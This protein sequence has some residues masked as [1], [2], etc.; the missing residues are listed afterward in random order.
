MLLLVVF[1]LFRWCNVGGFLFYI[2]NGGCRV[3][4]L[5]VFI[6]IGR[7]DMGYVIMKDGVEFFYKDWG[8][9]DV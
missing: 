4:L 3:V 1:F 8:L 9:C 2:G 6:L 5:F 7:S